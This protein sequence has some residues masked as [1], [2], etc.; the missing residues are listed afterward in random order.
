MSDA[1]SCKIAILLPDLRGGGA[2]RV[3][4]NLANAFAE[5]GITVDVL[6][7]SVGGDYLPQLH[8]RVGTVD[9]HAPRYR[10]VLRPLAAY[11]RTHR[12]RA[13]L[14][15]MWPMTAI[16]ELA[17]RLAGSKTRLVLAEHTTWSAS[18]LAAIRMQRWLLRHSMRWLHPHADGVVAVSRGAADDLARL[19][20]LDPERIRVIH[21][22]LV[23]GTETGP[24]VIHE[25]PPARWWHGEHKRI[26]AVGMLRP[27]KDY[28]TLLRAFAALRSRVPARLLILG[29]GDCRGELERLA[30]EL[31]IAEALDMPGF[32]EDPTPYFRHADLH[33]LSSSGEGFGN[34]IVEAL[35]AGTP[36]VSTDCRSGPREILGDGR[37]GRLVPVGDPLAMAEAMAAALEADHD[38]AALRARAAEFSIAAGAARYLDLLLPERAPWSAA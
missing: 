9:L 25:R 32:I 15:C 16:A 21:N 17:R 24:A 35:A 20:G 27:I 6:M 26:L 22:P 13:L 1:E 7:M 5:R 36:V 37:Y 4:V 18:E 11:L 10:S 33:V 19:S 2:E 30:M 23:G 3:V 8:A 28:P 34:V 38:R 31:G 14:A 29:D 12:P